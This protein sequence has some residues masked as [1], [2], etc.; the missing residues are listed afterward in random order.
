MRVRIDYIQA[1]LLPCKSNSSQ[2]DFELIR[3]LE[4]E[5]AIEVRREEEF[6]EQKASISW[7]KSGD[8]NFAFFHATAL[9]G[10]KRNLIMGLSGAMEI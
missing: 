6:W 1:R 3:G 4:K 8:K 10:R 7:L 9:Q 5:L 2:V